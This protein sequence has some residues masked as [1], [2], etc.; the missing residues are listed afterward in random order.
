MEMGR[1][2]RAAE[3]VI[4]RDFFLNHNSAHYKFLLSV[5]SLFKCLHIFKVKAQFFLKVS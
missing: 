2:K 1:V 3:N 5:V 4:Y